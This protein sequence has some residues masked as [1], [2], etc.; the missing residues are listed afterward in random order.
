MQGWAELG[1]SEVSVACLCQ[2]VI[3]L[4]LPTQQLYAG[5]PA[6]WWITWLEGGRYKGGS[7]EEHSTTFICHLEKYSWWPSAKHINY[8][9]DFHWLSTTY[10][11]ETSQ[12]DTWNTPMVDV[13]LVCL[14]LWPSPSSPTLLYSSSSWCLGS[15]G[16]SGCAQED[17]AV[18]R[19]IRLCSG[20]SGCAQE[21]PAV[22]RPKD[23]PTT[24]TVVCLDPSFIHL[25]IMIPSSV[26][27]QLILLLVGSWTCIDIDMDPR[28]DENK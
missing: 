13:S 18:L 23:S 20:G 10:A 24:P 5:R 15:S 22:L 25:C 16:G 9:P 2:E 21:D 8:R 12:K 26:T 7:E 17:P 6:P 28:K 3:F 19:K 14:L 11:W 1:S 27:K 4:S